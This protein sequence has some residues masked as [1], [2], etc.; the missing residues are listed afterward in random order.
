[1]KKVFSILLLVIS[2]QTLLAHP[3]GAHSHDTFLGAWGWLIFPLI[4]AIALLY[5]YTRKQS[6]KTEN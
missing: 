3:G 4:G 1:M 5:R 2:S 6:Q